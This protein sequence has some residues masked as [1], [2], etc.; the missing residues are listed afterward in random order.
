[1]K[2]KYAILLTEIAG[3]QNEFTLSYHGVHVLFFLA[4]IFAATIGNL[5]ND[6]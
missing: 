1:M 4:V 3:A 6:S 2:Q 5:F